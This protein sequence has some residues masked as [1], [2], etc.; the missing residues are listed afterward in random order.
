MNERLCRLLQQSFGVEP[1]D[2]TSIENTKGWDSMGHVAL[3]MA[4]ERE[5]SISISPADAID[6]TSVGKIDEF[7]REHAVASTPVN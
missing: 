2:A 3:I 7:L 5:F 4:L 6:L 1:D